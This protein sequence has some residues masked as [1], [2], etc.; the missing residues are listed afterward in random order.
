VIIQGLIAAGILFLLPDPGGGVLVRVLTVAAPFLTFPLIFAWKWI[1]MPPAMAKE[2]EE[3]RG[4]L[5]PPKAQPAPALG[6]HY[7]AEEKRLARAALRE[8]KTIVFDLGENQCQMH[9]LIGRLY[10]NV[11]KPDGAVDILSLRSM[12][13]VFEEQRLKIGQRFIHGRDDGD[14][15][16]AAM[17]SGHNDALSREIAAIE[18]MVRAIEPLANRP[19]LKEFAKPACETLSTANAQLADWI[20]DTLRRIA[21]R[22]RALGGDD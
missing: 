8:L 1:S 21:E 22:R 3:L 7:D 5:G 16:H 9:A 17:Q 11:G 2:L 13:D 14:E 4:Q 12:K 6:A 19:D 15:A 10:G 18:G 20:S